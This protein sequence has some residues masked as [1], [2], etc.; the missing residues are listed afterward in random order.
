[1][2]PVLGHI[3]ICQ[4]DIRHWVE[5][6]QQTQWVVDIEHVLEDVHGGMRWTHQVVW[7][8]SIAKQQW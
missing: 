3:E 7:F 1:V 6:D 2:V 5:L 4:G 8:A